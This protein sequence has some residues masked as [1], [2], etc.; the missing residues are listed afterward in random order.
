M[1]QINMP[2]PRA[3]SANKINS[4][5]IK[6]V[7]NPTFASKMYMSTAKGIN[8]SKRFIEDEIISETGKIMV[9]TLM[10]FKT[11]LASITELTIVTVALAK[12][13]QK[14]SPVRAN[15]G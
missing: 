6:N 8:D 11:P 14:I 10:D 7:S 9:G 2:T 5:I 12:K 1:A 15:S 13:F 3:N 4:G